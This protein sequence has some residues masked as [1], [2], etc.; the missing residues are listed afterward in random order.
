MSRFL[1][2]SDN[3]KDPLMPVTVLPIE[4]LLLFLDDPAVLGKGD[5]ARF[6]SLYMFTA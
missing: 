2:L 1:K 6:A 4:G 3:W 5:I